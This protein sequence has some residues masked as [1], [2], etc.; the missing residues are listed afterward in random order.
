M[1]IENPVIVETLINKIFQIT[2]YR[3]NYQQVIKK[4]IDWQNE[5]LITEDQL[6]EW[7]E[8]GAEYIKK[9][10]KISKRQAEREMSTF[11]LRYRIRIAETQN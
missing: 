1:R 7:M 8:W 6:I 10:F 5:L 3:L 11:T 4:E 2:K 9:C